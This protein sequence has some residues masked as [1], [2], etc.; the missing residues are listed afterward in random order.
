VGPKHV[1]EIGNKLNVVFDCIY[2]DLC[3]LK[4]GG[5]ELSE[6]EP[7]TLIVTILKQVQEKKQKATQLHIQI[8]T[9]RIY[10]C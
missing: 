10:S 4:H 6:K 7:L 1:E 5:D 9:L 3:Y 8:H 2:C